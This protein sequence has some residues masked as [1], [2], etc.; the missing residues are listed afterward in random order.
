MENEVNDEDSAG[1]K[2]NG[3]EVMNDEIDENDN[4]HI[5][6]VYSNLKTRTLKRMLRR[7]WMFKKKP[8]QMKNLL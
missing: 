4:I 2:D 8:K 5:A 1:E 3:Q 6:L 7:W